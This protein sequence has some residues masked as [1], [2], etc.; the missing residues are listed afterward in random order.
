MFFWGFFFE[1]LAV[2]I[3]CCVVFQVIDFIITKAKG[4]R[5]E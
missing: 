5:M 3:G 1:S 4:G 2:C